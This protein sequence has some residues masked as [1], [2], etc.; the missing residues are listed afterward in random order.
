MN[1]SI[2]EFINY[3]KF[4]YNFNKISNGL[5]YIYDKNYYINIIIDKNKKLF[6][7]IFNEEKN[8][9]YDLYVKINEKLL[10][11]LYKEGVGIKELLINVKKG[12]IKINKIGVF[13]FY[14]FMKN[15]NLCPETW[16]NFIKKNNK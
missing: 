7:N 2:K 9:N 13:K 16:D 11:N 8:I 10:I 5:F 15:F 12:N 4:S 6:I 1:N 3:L 14:G